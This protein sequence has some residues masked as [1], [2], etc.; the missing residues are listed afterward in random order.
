MEFVS[1]DIAAQAPPTDDELGAYLT[2]HPD[3][4]RMEQ[5]FTFRQLYLDPE[6]HGANLAQDTAQVLARLNQAGSD[7]ESCVDGRSVHAG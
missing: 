6:K 2:A 7:I 4:F 5:Q 3:K 1:D